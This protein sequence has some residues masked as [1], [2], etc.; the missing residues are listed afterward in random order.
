MMN[1]DSLRQYSTVIISYTPIHAAAVLI[2][3]SESGLSMQST[4]L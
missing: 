4:T 2:D 1:G 3:F